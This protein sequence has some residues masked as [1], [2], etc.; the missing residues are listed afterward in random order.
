M[1]K[2]LQGE[3]RV[4]LP[5]S[6]RKKLEEVA[7][8]M[9]LSKEKFEKLKREV[10]EEYLRCSF[11]PGEA[12]GIVAAQSI[13]EPSTQMTMRTY[14]VA[15]GLGVKVTLGLPRLIE[16]FDARKE[17]K[18]KSMTIYMKSD[19]NTAEKARE[20][21]ERIIERKVWYFAKGVSVDLSTGS[22]EVELEDMRR[23]PTIA[24]AIKDAI[25]GVRVRIT[26]NSIVVSPTGSFEVRD[27][28]KLKRRVME[29]SVSG[30]KGI[31][32]AIIRREGK[33]WIIETIGS[34]LEEILKMKEVDEKRTLSNDLHEVYRILGI[35]AARNL[36][37]SEVMKTLQ[38]Q[39][40][41]VD[42]RHV[43][44]VA[45]I[46]TVDGIVKPIG[47]YGVAG[48]KKSVLARAAFEETIKHLIRAS[49]KHEEDELKGIFENVMINQVIPSGT[50]MFDLVARKEK[51]K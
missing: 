23:A 13:S 16:I 28:Q 5:M 35:E 6:I 11:E 21:A 3:L 4:E 45:D 43:M 48:S 17:P 34:N 47:R 38:Q 29:L 15:G 36:I 8:N 7:K 44:L 46:M 19:Y 31:E 18:T 26:K 49:V 1:S 20:F 22:I 9:K 10:E 37:V 33:D 39:A 25:K 2:E 51:D 40:L 24:K 14:H 41:D 27:L 32:N 12:V 50:G 42:I 30:V